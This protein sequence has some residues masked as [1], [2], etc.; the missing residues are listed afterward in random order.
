MVAAVAAVATVAAA[1]GP[2]RRRRQRHT[3]PQRMLLTLNCVVIL[4]CF[5]GAAGLLISRQLGNS[6]TRVKL[7]TPTT[8]PAIARPP[9]TD[10]NGDTIPASDTTAD[11]SATVETFP[12]ADPEAQNFLI[13]GADNNACIDPSSP[14]AGA[15]GNRE[16]MGERSDTIMIMRVDPA[17]K[18]AAVL[19]FPRDLWVTID[20]SN[21]KNRIN[22]AYVRD[23]PQKLINT[24]FGNFGLVVDHFIQI[25]FCAFKTIVEGLGGVTVPFTY[26]ARDKNTGLNVPTKGCYTFD[27]DHALAY[28]RSR[29]YQYQNDEGKWKEDPASDLGR[30]SRQQD[31]LRR[32]LTAALDRGVTDPGVARSLIKAAQENIVVD[33]G[34]TLTRM[35]QFAG[36]LR[37]FEPDAIATYQIEAVGDIIGGNSV[38]I[39][40][41]KGDNMRAILTI[42]RG[43]APLAG[44]PE[45][46]FDTTTTTTGPA[47]RSTTT[48]RP[49][50]TTTVA[51]PTVTAPPPEENVIGIVPPRDVSC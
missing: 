13:T 47:S 41:I 22:T 43:E 46:V 31:F 42:F 25:D 17:T 7:V 37:D 48:T 45:Q 10:E 20:G 21:S 30:V 24:I 40:K 6:L 29:H 2:K 23:D 39:P 15:F 19:S 14:Y 5:V 27:G 44:A 28:V 9:A 35:L 32:V 1:N 38:L 50:A 12:D 26:P 33:T 36:V 11:S 49:G 16:T 8:A 4:A 18:R 51:M 3:W 34:L